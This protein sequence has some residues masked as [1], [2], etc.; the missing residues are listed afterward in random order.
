MSINYQFFPRS[1]PLPPHLEGVIDA[2]RG[3]ESVFGA[4]YKSWQTWLD[5][6]GGGT[7]PRLE[8]N[9]ALALVR[10]ALEI[11]GWD[12]EKQNHKIEVVVLWGVNGA[13]GK[14]YQADGKLEHSLGSHTVL[15]VEAGGAT[16]NNLWRKDLMEACV[17]P[18]VDY[19]VIAVRNEYTSRDNKSGKAKMNPDF[20]KVHSELDA[21]YESDRLVLP[22]KGVLLIGY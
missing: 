21:L 8:S 12:V 19:L 7:G 17:M 3:Q 20:L 18:T 11:L 6:G 16:A 1:A 4:A 5:A 13:K 9:Q 15:E 14:Y 10:P 22:L 2:F